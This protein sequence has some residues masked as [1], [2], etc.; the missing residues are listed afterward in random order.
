MGG[1]RPDQH[2]IAPGE[3]GA[4]DYKDYPQVGRGTSSQDNTTRLDKEHL[5]QRPE[6]AE[7]QPFLPDVPSPSAHA[8]RGTKRPEDQAKTSD[9]ESD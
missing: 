4:S 9:S 2:N 5:A 8:R 7:D 3:A 1:K 6:E